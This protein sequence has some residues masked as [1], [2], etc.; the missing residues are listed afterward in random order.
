MTLEWH[1]IIILLVSASSLGYHIGSYRAYRRGRADGVEI[2]KI[3]ERM[4]AK[5]IDIHA[6]PP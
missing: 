4:K 2:G 1:T 3:E 5:G 6:V